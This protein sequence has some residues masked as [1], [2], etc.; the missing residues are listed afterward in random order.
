MP[1]A[2]VIFNPTKVQRSDLAAVVDSAALAAGWS[3]SV[4]IETTEDDPG[5]GMAREAVERRCDMVLAVGGDGTIRSVAQGMRGSG[6]P[7]GLCPRGTGNLLA[8]NLEL[9][10]DNLE[11]S[12]DAAF[13]G[14]PR[15]V[16]LGVATW[17]RS[18]GFQQERV[19]VVMAGLGLDAKIMATT[20][21]E[22]KE[23]VGMLAYVKAGVDALRHH[24]RMHLR[25]RF[26]DEDSHRANVHTVLV[27]NCGSIGNNVLLM[28]DAAVD[29]GLLDVAAVRPQGLLGWVK[30]GWKVL[31][32]NAILRRTASRL[33]RRNRDRDRSLTYQQTRQIELTL[34]DPEEIEL[35]G[36]VF[37]KVLA[38]RMRVDPG[39][40][41]VQM[42]SGWTPEPGLSALA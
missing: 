37:G 24:H 38:V 15:P 33:V 21:D 19:F 11:E 18:D 30:V 29:D 4:W 36:D 1:T 39:A 32:D 2:A 22:L 34:R 9:T 35:D 23:K 26:D 17:S 25:F 16:D 40:L 6:I 10:L 41:T 12:V 7:M 8:R 42:P 3:Q 14:T 27:G 5:T 31:V 28:P 20:D 13:N